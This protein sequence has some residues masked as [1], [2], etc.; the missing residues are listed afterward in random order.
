MKGNK[1]VEAVRNGADAN[2]KKSLE[3]KS[4]VFDRKWWKGINENERR[5]NINTINRKKILKIAR[6]RRNTKRSNCLGSIRGGR[7]LWGRGKWCRWTFQTRQGKRVK[8]KGEA[9]EIIE[10]WRGQE[11]KY[12]FNINGRKIT[13]WSMKK[14]KKKM[15]KIRN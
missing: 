6:C 9:E 8:K 11:E 10:Q 15:A 13:P 3:K 5:E 12:N 4:R 2:K 14:V 7:G 1:L